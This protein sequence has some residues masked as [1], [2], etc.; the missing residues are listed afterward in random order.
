MDILVATPT[1][2]HKAYILDEFLIAFEWFDTHHNISL[3]MVDTSPVD[4]DGENYKY[5][6]YKGVDC[7]HVDPPHEKIHC[8]VDSVNVA[9]E[10][11]LREAERRKVDA[12]LS[13]EVDVICPPRT[14]NFMAGAMQANDAC[15]VS[16]AYDYP[17]I[18]L[19]LHAL[20]CT[21]F[22]PKPFLDGSPLWVPGEYNFEDLL[23]TKPVE[24]G[25][26]VIKMYNYLPIRHEHNIPPS[27]H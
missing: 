16:H 18:P 20:G 7:I 10:A 26:H 11:I 17:A 12:V 3:F 24:E 15:V 14:P 22:D 27:A 25:L 4:D 9:W 21:I 23:F 5:M 2:C 19:G 6:K 8:A 13:I 1:S